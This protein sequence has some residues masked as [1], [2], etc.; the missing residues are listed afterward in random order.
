M[1]EAQPEIVTANRRA[2]WA[3]GIC[4]T[5]IVLLALSGMASITLMYDDPLSRKGAQG[6]EGF[7]LESVIT[8]K[9][10][11]HLIHTWGG[12]VTIVVAGWAMVELFGVSRVAKVH[13]ASRGRWIGFLAVIGGL[14]I[15]A[16][17]LGL[18]WSGEGTGQW[19]K[20]EISPIGQKEPPKP[21]KFEDRW[22]DLHTRD[23]LY[24]LGIGVILMVLAS[25]SSKRLARE[26]TNDKNRNESTEAEAP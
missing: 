24:P 15:L 13:S 20:T 8:L 21:V 19:L 6:V 14:F 4:L 17:V 25:T 9:P 12:Y 22:T 16:S 2:Q 11:I 3:S 10:L 5:M 26:V 7:V 23:L 1:D 18:I